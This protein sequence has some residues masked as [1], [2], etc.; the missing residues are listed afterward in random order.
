VTVQPQTADLEARAAR[1]SGTA[2]VER[3]RPFAHPLLEADRS[4]AVVT[5][6]D[7]RRY[8][9]CIGGRGIFNLGRRPRHVL[10]ALREAV[11]VVDQG[12]FPLISAEKADLARR[13]AAFA[14]GELDCAVFSVSRG[15][16]L[17]AACKLARG[18]TRRGGLITVDGGWYGETGFALALSERRDA[19]DFAPL[20]PDVRSVPMNDLTAAETAIGRLDAA[21]ILEPVQAEN[22]CRCVEPDYLRAV[23][24]ICRDRGVLLVLDETQSGMGRTGARFAYGHW[25]VVPDILVIGESLAAG[26]FP[27]CATLFAAPLQ[28]FLN[29]HPL[30]HLSTFGGSDVGCLVGQAALDDY[31]ALRPWENAAAMG[32]RLAT[33]LQTLAGEHPDIVRGVSGKGLLLAL[34]LTS[35]E[36]AAALSAALADNGVLAVPGR[37]ATASVVLRPSLLITDEE[38][39]HLVAGCRAALAALAAPPQ[40]RDT[41]R[42]PRRSRSAAARR[43]PD[44]GGTTAAKSGTTAAGTSAAKRRS[45]APGRDDSSAKTS[46][47]TRKAR[48]PATRK[49]ASAAKA[50]SGAPEKGT[51]AGTRRPAAQK[52]GKPA[53][54]SRKP[55]AKPRRTAPAA[56]PAAEPP[57]DT[58]TGA[59]GSTGTEAPVRRKRPSRQ[60]RQKRPPTGR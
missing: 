2:Q 57:A 54:K 8:I 4:G 22:G 46:E 24:R 7:G 40:G 17:D 52:E 59:A 36:Q 58:S 11:Q 12:N 41:P 55:A 14:P 3:A 13:L 23:A 33:S 34:E 28:E 56:G 19:T 44:S 6:S 15:E 27:I 18:H 60:Q 47:S 32:E 42:A 31:E 38:C 5:G 21:F 10:A 50:P 49:R 39:E 26:A 51:S 9:D 29:D 48:A 37:V 20:I 35:E 43:A 45:G 30:I 16:A 53:A 25:G 1:V